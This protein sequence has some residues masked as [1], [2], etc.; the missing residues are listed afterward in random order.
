MVALERS[1]YEMHPV[2]VRREVAIALWL[3]EETYNNTGK[4][5]SHWSL[6]TLKEQEEWLVHADKFI[7]MMRERGLDLR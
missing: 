1:I 7:K 6:L 5:R 2:A 3:L 4:T